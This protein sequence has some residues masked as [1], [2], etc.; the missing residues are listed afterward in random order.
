VL[1]NCTLQTTTQQQVRGA[2]TLRDIKNRMKTV[3]SIKKITQSMKSV[4]AS[5]LK[6]AEKRKDE[7]VPFWRASSGLIQDVPNPGELKNNIIVAVTSDRG[8]CGSANSSVVRRTR[9]HIAERGKENLEILCIGDK[10]RGGLMSSFPKNL[11]LVMTDLDKKPIQ[12][13]DVLPIADRIA[14][15]NYDELAVI[16]N[17]FINSIS[18][19]T[20]VRTIPPKDLL[21]KSVKKSMS[22]VS[23]EGEPK[24]IIGDLHSYYITAMLFT[25]IIENQACEIGCRMSSMDSATRNATDML[26]KLTLLYNRKRQ[27][28]ITN[29]LTEIISGAS[30]IEAK[31]EY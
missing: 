2:A 24:E 19:E 10:A 16:S 20:M 25:S 14:T 28:N 6:A 21:I 30:S 12:F 5:R 7:T 29:E 22:T 23:F 1:R 15:V 31:V 26:G 8:L 13:S 11:S 4:A 3:G 9:K 27:A 17:K 18:F